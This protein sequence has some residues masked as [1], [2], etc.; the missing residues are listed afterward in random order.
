MPAHLACLLWLCTKLTSLLCCRYK[1]AYWE[2]VRPPQSLAG[3]KRKSP[4]DEECSAPQSGLHTL[5]AASGSGGRSVRSEEGGSARQRLRSTGKAAVGTTDLAPAADSMQRAEQ[6]MRHLPQCAASAAAAQALTAAELAPCCIAKH[7]S[8]VRGPSQEACHEQAGNA[9]QPSQ[10][11][12]LLLPPPS[13]CSQTGAA[14]LDNRCQAQRQRDLPEA[15]K[16]SLGVEQ[17]L[18]AEQGAGCAMEGCPA[19]LAADRSGRVQVKEEPLNSLGEVQKRQQPSSTAERPSRPEPDELA[20]MRRGTEPEA[21]SARPRQA[22]GSPLQRTPGTGGFTLPWPASDAQALVLASAARMD[23]LRE[24][25]AL[26]LPAQLGRTEQ[27]ALQ[28]RLN[29]E[30]REAPGDKPRRFMREMQ[31]SPA[32]CTPQT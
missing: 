18:G 4:F 22:Q 7:S 21:A 31:T 15:A 20:A 17:L 25:R 12:D 23:R 26:V 1:R 11:A 30:L 32:Q 9:S 14:G 27:H 13:A 24:E 10:A 8:G 28:L 29:G 5:Q 2:A 16:R 6:H 19:Q 3:R